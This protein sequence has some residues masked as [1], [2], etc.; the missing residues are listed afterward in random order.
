M[1]LKVAEQYVE[2]FRAMAKS[3]NTVVVPANVGDAGAMV[4][5]AM[6]ILKTVGTTPSPART[7]ARVVAEGLEEDHTFGGRLGG[8]PKVDQP[9]E[10]AEKEGDWL[11]DVPTARD[12]DADGHA[13]RKI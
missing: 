3:T 1:S 11:D 5:Q 12:G 2:A 10:A 9:L 6:A 7:S 4:A 13:G 8:L